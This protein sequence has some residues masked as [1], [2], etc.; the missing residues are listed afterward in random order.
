MKRWMFLLPF[1]LLLASCTDDVKFNNPAFQTLKDNVFWRAQNYTGYVDGNGNMILEGSLGYEKITLITKTTAVGSYILGADDIST[2]SY[3]NDLPA[4]E[5]EF[6][7]GTNKGN[8]QITITEYN[9]ET[10]T[11]SGTFK[12]TAVNMDESDTES[13][14]MNFTEGVFYKVPIAPILIY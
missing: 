1:I 8:G 10:N 11:I 9:K 5:K 13:P 6:S 4:Q 12:F 2:G 14:K 3:T 7:T